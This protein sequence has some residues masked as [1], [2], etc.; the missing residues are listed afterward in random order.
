MANL[1][2]LA[3]D[4]GHYAVFTIPQ[5]ET[6]SYNTSLASYNDVSIVVT[7]MYVNNSGSSEQAT[8]NYRNTPAFL[9]P[10]FSSTPVQL[11]GNGIVS[12]VNSGSADIVI[13][14]SD[15][16]LPGYIAQLYASLSIDS[17]ES[18][19]TLVNHFEDGLLTN[20]GSGTGFNYELFGEA[21][22]SGIAKFQERSLSL[23]DNG[24]PGNT[25]LVI[26][27]EVEG[28][29]AFDMS[30]DFTV[31]VWI[32]PFDNLV[33]VALDRIF[34]SFGAKDRTTLLIDD[35]VTLYHKGSTDRITLVVNGSIYAFV[36]GNNLPTG[37]YNL[38]TLTKVNDTFYF[39]IGGVLKGT[40]VKS[41]TTK[42]DSFQLGYTN[43]AAS[44]RNLSALYDEFRYLE[45]I[46]LYTST[47]TRPT[48]PYT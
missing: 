10:A 13:V 24:N 3:I 12:V 40:A 28:V 21:K 31:D 19:N 22:T 38:V 15:V 2:W 36:P 7:Q 4:E 42:F 27:K 18:N 41:I 11:S 1:N 47:F 37:T 25:G 17:G 16:P 35:S 14:F 48:V 43:I 8:I 23:L 44:T 9:I 45:G 46:G 29:G 32:S 30:E 34:F 39:F 26:N 33:P 20:S 5:G 6:Q